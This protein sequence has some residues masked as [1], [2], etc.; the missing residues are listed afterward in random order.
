MT[1]TEALT[2]LGFHPVLIYLTTGICIFLFFL[3]AYRH[4]GWGL[5][6]ILSLPLNAA[7]AIQR[8]NSYMSVPYIVHTALLIAIGII[9]FSILQDRFP[10][11]V[12]GIISAIDN[13]KG[14]RK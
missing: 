11:S 10:R 3:K 8:Q 13:V 12:K 6:I 4:L 9:V 5:L 2:T 7:F 1:I 14:G